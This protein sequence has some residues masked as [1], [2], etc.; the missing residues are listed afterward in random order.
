MFETN[1]SYLFSLLIIN[2]YYTLKMFFST[3]FIKTSVKDA[4]G[5]TLFCLADCITLL[6]TGTF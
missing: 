1:G 6:Q 3:N 5:C 4:F 2:K